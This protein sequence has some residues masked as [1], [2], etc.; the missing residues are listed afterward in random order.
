MNLKEKYNPEGSVLRETQLLM[1][2]ILDTVAEIL[3]R[4]GIPFWL[5]G[6]T[7]L[8][9]KRHGGFIPWDDDLDIDV[10]EKH[11]TQA[12]AA[13]ERELP[14]HLYLERKGKDPAY[15]LKWIKV[16]DRN[17]ILDEPGTKALKERGVFIDIFKARSIGK[18]EYKSVYAIQR[19]KNRGNLSLPAQLLAEAA[20]KLLGALF[21]F[22]KKQWFITD[23]MYMQYRFDRQTI[24]P[25]SQIL[26][27]GKL[28]PAPANTEA[29]LRQHYGNWQQI[30]SEDKIVQHTT[31]I[32]LNK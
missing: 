22:E 13:L 26:F 15:K 7:L 16:K 17:S 4:N 21:R 20:I 28:Y 1:L 12:I 23:N 11:Y 27:E 5:E 30:P 31:N 18:W 6:G 14:Q 29:Y 19:L 10:D 24:Y 9:A 32:I 8:G 3:N 2:S 25:L